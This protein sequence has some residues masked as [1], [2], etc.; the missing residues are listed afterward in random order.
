MEDKYK[1]KMVLILGLMLFLANG[2]NYAAAPLLNN[3]AL[4][5]HLTLSEAAMSVTAYM[6]SFGLFTLVFGPLSDRFGKI[7]VFIFASFGTSIFSILGATAFN[8]PSLVFF[9]A[10]NGI[11]GAGIFPIALALVGDAFDVQH[12]Q[13]AI[14]KTMGMAFLGAATA[15]VIGGTLAYFGSWR[16]VYLVYGFGELILAITM[17]RILKQKTLPAKKVNSLA[18]YHKVLSN[19]RFMGITLLIFLEGFSVFGSFTYSG[20]LIQQATMYPLILV[21]LILSVF[22]IGTVIGGRFATIIS[23]KTKN[24]F[25]VIVAVIGSCSLYILSTN[26]HIVLTI[27]GLFGFGAAFIMLQS[28]LITTLMEM[29]PEVKGAVMSLSGFNLFL[30]GACGTALNSYLITIYGPTTPFFYSAFLFFTAAFLAA[31]CVANCKKQKSSE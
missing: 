2:D 11:F 23:Q 28:T 8:L 17:T 9:R 13:S 31:I 30:G 19:P 10:M 27:V 6:L 24:A 14:G 3:I 20:V 25:L 21:G 4:D 26:L 7:H 1:S 16:L 29:H 18:G 22:G 15:T 12:R 5:L